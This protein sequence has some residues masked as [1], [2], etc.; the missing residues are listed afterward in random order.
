MARIDRDAWPTTI[1]G[2]WMREEYEP[3][4]VSVVVP[5]YNRAQFLPE[6]LDS[7]LMQTYRPI[8]LLVVDDGST[9]NTKELV[10]DWVNRHGG[11]TG[12]HVRYL[13]QP[14]SGAPA[15]RNLG[16]IES[17]GE[18]LQHLDSDDVLL[19]WS[20]HSHV[21]PM[22]ENSSVGFAFSPGIP[23]K[24]E[25]LQLTKDKHIAAEGEAPI[26]TLLFTDDDYRDT[27]NMPCL[28][29]LRRSVCIAIGPWH[30]EL[31][32]SQDHNYVTRFLQFHPTIWGDDRISYLGRSH[33]Q[34]RVTD[35][36]SN[37]AQSARTLLLSCDSIERMNGFGKTP[38]TVRERLALD[39]LQATLK[40][41]VSGANENLP[42]AVSGI[43]R[44][45]RYYRG[46]TKLRAVMLVA[47]VSLLGSRAGHAAFRVW[48]WSHRENRVAQIA[49]TRHSRSC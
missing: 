7:V 23:V 28:G 29:L 44:H 37:S 26:T 6:A 8:E 45:I 35:G 19:P 9:D 25:E 40:V 46:M 22:K 18:F 15:A 20:I 24:S 3:D 17:R 5:T 32:H 1:H 27:A 42:E 31:T 4:L 2:R 21:Q 10:T 38:R 14:N 12:F 11:E 16:Q 34:G 43:R 33:D 13:Q 47:I 41:L 49:R 30:E 39:Y 48:A 36:K